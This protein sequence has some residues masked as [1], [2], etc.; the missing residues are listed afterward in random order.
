M[1]A[2]AMGTQVPRTLRGNR[3]AVAVDDLQ[4]FDIGNKDAAVLLRNLY[5]ISADPRLKAQGTGTFEAVKMI[6]AL[7]QQSYTPANGAQ[8]Q[9]EFGRRLQQ[10]A[11]LIKADV[12]VEVACVD[13]D[14]W[15]HHSNAQQ[16]LYPFGCST[17]W[18]IALARRWRRPATAAPDGA[19]AAP[20]AGL[21]PADASRLD[22]E[23]AA[24]DR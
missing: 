12:G 6:E 24:Y 16:Q 4:K 2:V 10:V 14:G 23:L 15:D 1:R 9:G 3:G 22:A 5:G 8:Y 11:R 7:R 21:D 19:A 18:V 20:A 17:T 13:I